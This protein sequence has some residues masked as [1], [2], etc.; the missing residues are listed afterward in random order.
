[1]SLYAAMRPRLARPCLLLRVG[2]VFR[3]CYHELPRHSTKGT[4]QTSAAFSF[5]SDSKSSLLASD[6]PEATKMMHEW[7]E[8]LATLSE[9]VVSSTL[10]NDHG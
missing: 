8:S 2:H 9:A 4:T 7:D 1:M 3:G 5:S 6:P 10:L